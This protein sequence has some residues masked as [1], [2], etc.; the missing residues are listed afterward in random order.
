MT[1]TMTTTTIAVTK[2][3][4]SSEGVSE[5]GNG[6]ESIPIPNYSESIQI[7]CFWPK[8]RENNQFFTIENRFR[9]DSESHIFGKRLSPRRECSFGRPRDRFDSLSKLSPLVC[10]LSQKKEEG[11]RLTGA[12][13][14]SE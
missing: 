14:G 13:A 7:Q 6:D 11:L 10:P 5:E 9:I 1:T 4:R 2:V 8:N 12:A 3:G